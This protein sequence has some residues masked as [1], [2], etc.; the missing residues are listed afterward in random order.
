MP[1]RDQ[2]HP[3]LDPTWRLL[4]LAP[5]PAGGTKRS[6]VGDRRAGSISLRNRGDGPLHR[7]T[8]R[9]DAEGH[10][11]AHRAVGR[12]RHEATALREQIIGFTAPRRACIRSR[13][14]PET[15]AS[16]SATRP[17]RCT[18]AVGRAGEFIHQEKDLIF[19]CP[20]HTEFGVRVFGQGAERCWLVKPM[21]GPRRWTTGS[22]TPVPGDDELSHEVRTL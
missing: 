5:D 7:R 2:G 10:G 8:L 15:T 14:M 17:T 4:L 1:S 13:S 3:R 18:S 16:G 11:G 9:A 21:A 22:K 20:R 12:C 6:L 19:T